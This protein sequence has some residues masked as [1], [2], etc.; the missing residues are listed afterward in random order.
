MSPPPAPTPSPTPKPSYRAKQ[1]WPP[2]DTRLPYA[3]RNGTNAARCYLFDL[4][5]FNGTRGVLKLW[6]HRRAVSRH[7]RSRLAWALTQPQ[8]IL[9]ARLCY[10]N[11]IR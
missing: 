6:P 9:A 1:S 10:A 5:R 2:P 4:Y 11:A 3:K 8:I 7:T